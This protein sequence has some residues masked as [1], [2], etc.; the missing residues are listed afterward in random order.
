MRGLPPF[1]ESYFEKYAN[2]PVKIVPF[3]PVSKK[4]AQQYCVMLQ[5]YLAGIDIS[6]AHRGST[7][8]GIAGKGE[9]EIGIY[10]DEN[11]WD[12]VLAK[13]AQRYGPPEN[14]EENYARFNDRAGREEIEI[15]CLKGYEAEVDKKLHAYLMSRKDLLTEYEKLKRANAH[16]K[17]DY[18]I[19]KDTF[20]R[21]VIGIIP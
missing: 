11:T 10:A 12:S 21:R 16:S 8:F 1:P 6:I 4:K 13:L 14:R 9:I 18:M 17:K 3:D 19:A 5:E 20:L 15:I 2:K 7:Y